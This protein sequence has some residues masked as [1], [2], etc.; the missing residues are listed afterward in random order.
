MLARVQRRSEAT[1]AP[2][3]GI[4]LVP[5]SKSAGVRL[6]EGKGPKTP[7]PGHDDPR[8]LRNHPGWGLH[9]SRGS[10]TRWT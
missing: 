7:Q 10:G 5:S 2:C 4:S 9:P 6:C 1:T 8:G 3:R